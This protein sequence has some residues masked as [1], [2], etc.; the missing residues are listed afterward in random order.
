[1]ERVSPTPTEGSGVMRRR[2][3]IIAGLC[4]IAMVCTFIGRAAAGTV[5]CN[6]YYAICA[7]SIC[8]PTGGKVTVN[9]TSGGTAE[10]PEADCL[11]PIFY[12]R[13]FVDLHTGMM[14][15]T[16]APP[17]PDEVWSTY[18]NQKFIPQEIN[19]WAQRGPEAKTTKMACPASLNL[20]ESSVNC[21]GMICDQEAFVSGEPIVTCHCAL[22]ESSD[23]TALP[24]HTAFWTYAGQGDQNFCA[25]Y[26]SAA[27][28][29][30]P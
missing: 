18:S 8:T 6:G 10:F 26:P 21:W 3:R 23:G 14:Q 5:V 20:A 16:C 9:V 19:G 28:V 2:A 17:S 1:M 15:G 4:A 27:V 24:A 30:I 13:A 29:P 11:C 25:A 7:A 12:G 22:G